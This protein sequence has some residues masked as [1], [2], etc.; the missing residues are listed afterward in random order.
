[1]RLVDQ[2]LRAIDL[3]SGVGGWSFGLTMAGVEVVGSYDLSKD[4]NRT[5]SLN[6]GHVTHT[7][8]I[9]E[10][11]LEE[12]PDDVQVVVGSPPCTE[13]S[14][15]NRGGGGD[16]KD[17]LRDIST[18]L[19]I[20]DHLRP[21]WWVMENVPRV[22][23]IIEKELGFRGR[24]ARF[25]HLDIK[26]VIVNMEEYGIPQR[27]KR[28]LIGNINFDLLASYT[29][30][31]RANTLGDV[32]AAL[33]SETV[34]DPLFGIKLP[35]SRLLDHEP[36]SY[37]DDEERRINSAN[38]TF[39]PV[40]NAMPFP[41]P[42]TRSV[43]TITATCTRVSRESVVIEEPEK[44]GKFRRLTVR[45]RACL[46]GFPITYQFY[47]NSY[48]QKLRMIGNAVPPA[49]SFY[50]GQAITL[51]PPTDLMTLREVGCVLEPPAEAPPI[52]RPDR[53]GRAFSA[54]RSF[55]FAIPNLRLKSGVRF[56]LVNY[57]A[58]DRTDWGV[59]FVFGTSKDICEISLT[60]DLVERLYEF[61]SPDTRT[62]V[63]LEL[64]KL[65]DYLC[66]CN[67]SRMQAVWSH[68][69]PGG[70]R[71][72]DVL[73]ELG[74]SGLS[75]TKLLENEISSAAAVGAALD[76]QYGRHVSSLP[77]VAKLIRNAPLILA[78][79]F[80]GGSAN[81]QFSRHRLSAPAQEHERIYA[82]S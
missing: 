62:G 76:A 15:S 4:A 80:V 78:G 21:R 81:R 50:V 18:F 1:M 75:I 47:G 79:M 9:R 14:F 35:R 32:I 37:L 65:N 10:L 61:I 8:N 22:A 71:P 72:F 3:Y 41:D 2:V 11:A 54:M 77:G 49:F 5:N 23:A 42:L 69:G 26:S 12:L 43:R 56:E 82:V 57:P 52:T 73:D 30:S 53:A 28:C 59:R 39:H 46:Q 19:S 17:G 51:T 31:L 74:A 38:K 24:L 27:R 64:Q 60:A 45:E 63:Q 25:R 36:E 68:K 55:R 58:D 29:K 40:Y 20:V 70:T 6:N 7:A 67:I 16:L 48:G 33:G 34:E 13:F 44:Q 66:K